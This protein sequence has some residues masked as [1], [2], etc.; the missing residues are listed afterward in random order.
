MRP[1]SRVYQLVK[2]IL[3]GLCIAVIGLSGE[4]EDGF[5][6]AGL[7]LVHEVL[8]QSSHTSV[9]DVSPL[10]ELVVAP[11]GKPSNPGTIDAP[12]TLESARDRIR[13]YSRTRPG[14][15]KVVLRGGMYLFRG[16]FELTYR[17]TGSPENPIEYVAWNNEI[18]RLI[19]GDIIDPATLKPVGATDPNRTR[20][21]ADAVAHILVADI[22]EYSSD[23]GGLQSRIGGWDSVNQSAEIFID[24]EPLNLARYPKNVDPGSINLSKNIM[25]IRVTGQASPDAT[26]NYIFNGHDVFGR[27]TF[28]L[29]KG[30]DIWIISAD[31][32][33]PIWRLGNGRIEQPLPPTA[34]WGDQNGFNGPVGRFPASGGKATGDLF[35][36]PS[37]N[38]LAFPGFELIR[39]TDGETK[40][41]LTSPSPT[42]W[43]K[44]HEV[45]I[46][47]YPFYSWSA[48]HM[49]PLDYDQT[50]GSVSVSAK[51][52]YGIR[53]GQPVFFY[54]VL[55]ELTDPGEYFLD[56]ER[57]LLYVRPT[58]DATPREILLSRIQEPLLKIGNVGWIRMQGLRFECTKDL[59]VDAPDVKNVI[60]RNC[61]FLNA[62]G[63]GLRIGGMQN[64]VDG[65]HFKGLGKNGVQAWGGNRFTLFPSESRIQNCEIEYVSRLFWTYQPGIRIKS[66]FSST[67]DDCVGLI[68]NNNSIHN[69]PHEAIEFAGNDHQILCNDIHHTCQLTSDAGA[70]YTGRDWGSQG[71]VIQ[72]NLFRENGG[73]MGIRVSSIYIDDCAS[74]IKIESNIFYFSSPQFAIQ[75]GGGRDTIVRYNVFVGHWVGIIADNRGPSVINNRS[76]DSFN[77][78]AKI[79]RYNYK[80]PPWSFRYPNL[81]AIPNDWAQIINSHW[82]QPEGVVICGNMQ[83]GFSN[84]LLDQGKTGPA[85]KWFK[86]IDRNVEGGDPGF[87]NPSHGDFNV[88]LESPLFG[89]KNFPGIESSKIGPKHTKSLN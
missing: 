51:P 31:A 49:R 60:F 61:Y 14:V 38:K 44:L 35:L 19:G 82:L 48:V 62:G 80:L 50:R 47:G 25:S 89:I 41:E 37:N 23:L 66:A 16:P 55:E 9:L 88:R 43:T 34:S 39:N 5:R 42:K 22:S 15:L 20:L 64:L 56:R 18:P 21:A 81:A 27:P 36:E 7:E 86:I 53:T 63:Q 46:Y 52:L 69:L 77:L 75:L 57:K 11:N 45:M 58:N 28:R 67:Q 78:L 65:C 24:G 70:I 87:T 84:S 30:N 54:N 71:N 32:D 12:T 13:V 26:G 33:S 79:S 74:G 76:G 4:S 83:T 1:E 8:V 17:D 73:S 72:S 6:Q 29:Q 3:M 40:F 85:T 59:L 10:I 2:I 68:V